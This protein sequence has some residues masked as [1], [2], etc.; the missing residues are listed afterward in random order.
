MKSITVFLE[1]RYLK[2]ENQYYVVGIEN[3]N[4]FSR[5]LEVFDVVYVFSRCSVCSNLPNNAELVSNSNI[6]FIDTSLVSN[7]FEYI[8]LYNKLIP[9]ES[10]LLMRIPGLFTFFSMTLSVVFSRK[11]SL[12]MVTDPIQEVSCLIDKSIISK[13]KLNRLLLKFVSL[14]TRVGLNQS[15]AASFVT[16]HELQDRYLVNKWTE[17][18]K[19]A[20][21]YS[22]INLP[23]CDL[24]SKKYL[25]E[26]S[27]NYR[28]KIDHSDDITLLFV[29]ALDKD[30][31]GLDIFIDILEMLPD[32][33]KGVVMG[34][35]ILRQSYENRSKYLISCGR[36]KFLGYINN[37]QEKLDVFMSSDLFISC[38]KREGLPRVVI[39]A[40][41]KGIPVIS[42]EVSG[43]NELIEKKYIFS[44]GDS[45]AA[46][47]LILGLT[48]GDYLSSS[49]IN[50]DRAT[51]YT[52]ERL[53]KNRISFYKYISARDDEKKHSDG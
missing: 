31:K 17:Q 36:I 52:I 14:V 7:Y 22:S 51:D 8:S 40:M 15:V 5:Y 23:S 53:A 39:E 3:M 21:S 38:S 26:N 42:S 41:A 2:F 9:K 47:K 1:R 32:N 33:Y 48:Y 43:I 24:V 18:G 20:F 25:L 35:G 13:T 50:L 10:V 29:G 11:F 19:Y 45:K 6:V 4:F 12:E 37:V 30:F 28:N 49:M 44:Q 34:D 16:K 27:F 46:V